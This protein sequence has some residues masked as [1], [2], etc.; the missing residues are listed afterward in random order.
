LAKTDPKCEDDAETNKIE[1]EIADLIYQ[2]DLLLLEYGAARRILATIDI[3]KFLPQN[4]ADLLDKAKPITP[5]GVKLDREK[6]TAREDAQ[7]KAVMDKS[8]FGLIVLGGS[9]DLSDS[10][11]RLG[12][13]RCEYIRVTTRRFKEFSE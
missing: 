6:V 10:V 11:R 4:D 8:G 5:S 3:E 1:V 2:H 12:Q 13:E 9:H 7:V